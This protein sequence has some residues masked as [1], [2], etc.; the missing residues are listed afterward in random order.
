MHGSGPPPAHLSSAAAGFVVAAA[1]ANRGPS[2]FNHI[3]GIAT[4]YPIY[5]SGPVTSSAG[6]LMTS[7]GHNMPPTSC[8]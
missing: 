6:P 3:A 2:L 4:P 1:A 7:S 8:P 5:S